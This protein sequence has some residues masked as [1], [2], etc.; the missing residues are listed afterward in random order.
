M[1]SMTSERYRV[2]VGWDIKSETHFTFRLTGERALTLASC[3]SMLTSVLSS[4]RSILGT[5]PMCIFGCL[6]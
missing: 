4:L 5:L 1:S 6:L 2:R 3:K